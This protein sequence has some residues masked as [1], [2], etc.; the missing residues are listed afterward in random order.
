MQQVKKTSSRAEFSQEIKI[1]TRFWQSYQ[2]DQI[3]ILFY[4]N[5]SNKL[6]LKLFKS[7]RILFYLDLLNS[8]KLILILTQI[9]LTSTSTTNDFVED[10]LVKFYGNLLVA[11]NE[12]LELFQSKWWDYL[13]DKWTQFLWLGLLMMN[14]WLIVL[15]LNKYAKWILLWFF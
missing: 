14:S 4:F 10:K 3:W 13:C 9:Y 2:R 11:E 15:R 8:Y 6:S 5:V 7:I 1:L 12:I